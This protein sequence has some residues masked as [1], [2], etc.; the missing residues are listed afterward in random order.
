MY[1][2]QTNRNPAPETYFKKKKKKINDKFYKK[3][4]YKDDSLSESITAITTLIIGSITSC[5]RVVSAGSTK[6][7]KNPT[8]QHLLSQS[9]QWVFMEEDTS[10]S[11]QMNVLM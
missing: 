2:V 4:Q 11:Y 10:I 8:A 9:D 6:R 1:F 7:P 3:K 5:S